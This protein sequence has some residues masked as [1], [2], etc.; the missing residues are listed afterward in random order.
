MPVKSFRVAVVDDDAVLALSLGRILEQ[1]GHKPKTYLGPGPFLDDL[2]AGVAF[3]CVLLD[4]FIG[5]QRG[6]DTFERTRALEHCFPAIMITGNASTELTMQAMEAGFKYIFEKPV[7]PEE[8]ISR[9]ELHC[10]AFRAE[11]DELERQAERLRILDSLSSRE[12]EVLKRMSHGKLNKQIAVEL[13]V[14]LRTVETY[15]GR[16]ME[17]INAESLADAVAFAIAVGLRESSS[18][19][20]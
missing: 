2:Q 13:N 20:G 10:A 3:D 15:R 12:R 5:E 1:Y 14:G 8:L 16:V 9:V 19:T 7:S 17:K 4:E 11:A 6:L 18:Q